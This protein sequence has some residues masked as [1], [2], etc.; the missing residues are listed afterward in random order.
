V[1]GVAEEKHHSVEHQAL[2]EELGELLGAIQRKSREGHGE[3][4]PGDECEQRQVNRRSEEKVSAVDRAPE[5][6]Q[7]A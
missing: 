1:Y 3:A 7:D 6:Q 4:D 2:L 5:N